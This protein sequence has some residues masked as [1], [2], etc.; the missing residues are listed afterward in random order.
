MKNQ[1]A[2]VLTEKGG[3][4][5]HHQSKTLWIGV[6]AT[7]LIGVVG[8]GG[9]KGL[10]GNSNQT[11]YPTSSVALYAKAKQEGKLIWYTSNTRPVAAAIVQAFESKYPGI[12]VDWFQAGGS[13]ILSKVGAELAAGGLKA[14]VVDYSDGSAILG[15]VKQGLFAQFKPY[16]SEKVDPHLIDP[17]GFWISSGGF[18]TSTL[19]Y[20]TN[21]V[22]GEEIPTSWEDITKPQ[23]A[24]KVS[25]GS[26]DY[27]GT[28]L[29]TIQGW[30]QALGG[31]S[32]LQAL[33][34]NKLTVMQSFGDTENAIVSGQ[35][36]IGVVLSFRAYQDEAS[37]KP[38]QVVQPKEGEVAMLTTM[39][40]NA[41]APDPYTARLFEDYILSDANQKFVASTYFYP[42]RTD[43]PALPAL[44]AESSIKL[45][46]PDETKLADQ[47]Y[48][49]QMKQTFGTDVNT[50]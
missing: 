4:R 30:E 31:A 18:F 15:Q 36:P 9:N 6:S 41:K 5:T 28:A 46:W 50:H 47:S 23:W 1:K 33:G 40:I 19:A 37:G 14:D 12:K 21:Q 16:N 44:P 17:N 7:L 45:I 26:P 29:S 2:R 42:A 25:F 34:K 27:A 35:T 22:K 10:S 39:G 38:I 13:Q 3:R 24:G 20:N 8:C 49:A 32:F 48:V 43:I 11:S